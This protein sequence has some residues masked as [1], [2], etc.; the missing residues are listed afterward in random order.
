MSWPAHPGASA[1]SVQFG[2]DQTSVFS[3]GSDGRL[4]E[5]SL[6]SLRSVV[7]SV[8]VAVRGPE[9]TLPLPGGGTPAPR[10]ATSH[11]SPRPACFRQE[12]CSAA[13]Q[14][15][16]APPEG[17]DPWP[18]LELALEASGKGALLSSGTRN[19]ALVDLRGWTVGSPGGVV[20]PLGGHSADVTSVDWHP[21]APVCLTGSRDGT[22]RTTRLAL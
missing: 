13:L 21:Q 17:A 8:S 9:A 20:M 5:W 19:A 16:G 12:F 10:R 2:P 11:G 15:P 3:A 1:H 14:R 18:R 22:C 7:R 6:H 4:V